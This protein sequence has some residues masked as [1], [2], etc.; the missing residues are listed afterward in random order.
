MSDAADEGWR[1]RPPSEDRSGAV[2]SSEREPDTSQSSAPSVSGGHAQDESIALVRR[3]LARAVARICPPWLAQSA[4]DLTQVALLRVL[5]IVRGGGN[6]GLSASYL[7][8]VAYSAAVDEMRR[9]FRR[10]E[11]PAEDVPLLAVLR[12]EV[13]DPEQEA[14][15]EEIGRGITRGL[16]ELVRPRRLAVTHFLQGCTVPEVARTLGWSTKKAEHL[17]Y[18]GLAQLR[19]G[20]RARGLAP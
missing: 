7:A 19:E 9:R 11:V 6:Q 17:V 15:A 20:L 10:R 1:L 4:E 18:R 12:A 13:A 14:T 16:E 5:E 2:P 8:K 3:R